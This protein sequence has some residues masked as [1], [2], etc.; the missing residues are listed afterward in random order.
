MALPTQV[1]ELQRVTLTSRSP[2]ATVVAKL[3]E[4]IGRVPDFAAFA[5]QMEAAKTYADLEKL[6]RSVVGSADLVE[7][8]RLDIGSVLR[9]AN[10]PTAGQ[11]F[12]IIAGNP[13]IMKQMVEHVPDAASYAPITILVD[14]RPEGVHLSYDR[15]AAALAP[16]GNEAAL[17]VARDLDTKVEKLLTHAAS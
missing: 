8:M 13:L 2:F 6:V 12:R 17:T 7:F 10:G 9:K 16:Y 11:S 1:V 4:G 14:E 5:R 3:Y 15:V